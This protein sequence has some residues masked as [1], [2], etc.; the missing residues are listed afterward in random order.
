M[1]ESRFP[2]IVYLLVL[3][4]A[5]L[6]YGI[7][8]LP[9]T[10]FAGMDFLNL[11]YPR[12]VL[13][14]HSWAA[15]RIPLWNW[16]EWGGVPLLAALQGAV[17]YPPT[18]FSLLLPMP[19][20]LQ[21]FVFCHLL[22]AGIGAARLAHKVL[23]L[24]PPATAFVAITYMGNAFF[25]GRIE[26]FQIIAANCLLPWLML[27][28][29]SGVFRRRGYALLAVVWAMNLLA[30]HPQ[31][32]ALNLLGSTAF[33]GLALL[34]QPRRRYP[35]RLTSLKLLFRPLLR[36]GLS[37]TLG[38]ALAAIQL[39]PTW[40]L[41]KLSE[42]IW[43][44][45]D[46]TVPEL[47][48][49]NLPALLIPN[50]YNHITGEIGRVM[51][52]TEL[53]IYGGILAVPLTLVA[54]GSCLLPWASRFRRVPTRPAPLQGYRRRNSLL[55]SCVVVWLLCFWFALGRHGGLATL[56]FDY[57]PFFRQ[58]RGAARSLNVAALMMA[59]LA[60]A[61]F[62]TCSALWRRS[63]FA[64]GLKTPRLSSLMGGAVCMA[65]ASGLSIN[66]LPALKSVMVSAAALKPRPLLPAD[67]A[68]ELQNDG[69]RIYRF[70]AM[71][72]DLYLNN[73]RAAVTERVVR[74]QPN[75]ASLT[76]IGLVDGY[77]EGLLPPRNR[78]NLL[79]R[80]NRNLRGPSP[81]AALLAALNSRIMLSE[82]PLKPEPGAWQP[83]SSLISRPPVVPPLMD[84]AAAS[85]QFWRSAYPAQRVYSLDKLFPAAGLQK[86][87]L[88][89]AARDFPLNS[90]TRSAPA[91]NER[92][93]AFSAVTAQQL[94]ASAL[95]LHAPLV[96]WEW[97]ALSIASDPATSAVLV[98]IPPYPG[99]KVEKKNEAMANLIPSS[100]LFYVLHTT[101]HSPSSAPLKLI[102]AP[103]S[104][105]LGLFITLAAMVLLT[106]SYAPLRLRN[107]LSK[108]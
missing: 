55:L 5:V 82:Y 40:E 59:L 88:A 22:A 90:L 60:G 13:T 45:P 9:G 33:V 20:G 104:F 75:L 24:S 78:A 99:W 15:G 105:R 31:F 47:T 51:D 27:A 6:I 32:A 97:N 106:I 3:I 79:R 19:Y 17:F 95:R 81:D 87:F 42:R 70:M 73:S 35:C 48:W 10:T 34:T 37:I 1:P 46:P 72:S 25:V 56:V 26:Q 77:E 16:F 69:G 91:F 52:F 21:V 93:H 63:G 61:G 68:K 4:A 43:P 11:N 38:T 101:K 64:A 89:A 102:F 80:Y 49:S 30:G 14:G 83:A 86:A 92:S 71:D 94:T 41:G 36:V 103:Y 66:H 85:Y 74:L 29:Y 28:M 18:W 54:I 2:P 58:S 53:G 84:N 67:L 100:A 108:D 39:L 107:K 44:Y 23:R 7:I 50:Y 96:P 62:H 8:L 76:G 98:L 57:V 65:V 12:V